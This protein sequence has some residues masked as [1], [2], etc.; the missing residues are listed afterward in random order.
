MMYE[1]ENY[2][3]LENNTHLL[4][5]TTLDNSVVEPEND[6]LYTRKKLLKN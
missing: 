1:N 6:P 2:Q 5:W 4:Q 3:T